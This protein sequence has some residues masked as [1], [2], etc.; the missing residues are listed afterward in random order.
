MPKKYA[1]NPARYYTRRLCW[2]LR[3]AA[4]KRKGHMLTK[5][6]PLWQQVLQVVAFSAVVIAVFTLLV[7]IVFRREGQE[8]AKEWEREACQT[9]LAEQGDN[10]WEIARRDGNE[11]CLQYDD[12]YVSLQR[13]DAE[14]A[15][16]VHANIEQ[17]MKCSSAC[18]EVYGEGCEACL[19]AQEQDGQ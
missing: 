10:A 11:Y 12:Y 3:C 19:K 7:V 2:H 4:A 8:A 16:R 9:Y 13:R 14:L 5:P 17:N 18:D 6:L 1:G 15:A